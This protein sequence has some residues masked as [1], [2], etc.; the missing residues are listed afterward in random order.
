MSRWSEESRRPPWRRRPS[1]GQ[2]I[3]SL[4]RPPAPGSAGATGSSTAGTIGRRVQLTGSP[5]DLGARPIGPDR[6]RRY[7]IARRRGGKSTRLLGLLRSRALGSGCGTDS[8]SE[9]AVDE[10]FRTELLP[11]RGRA[12]DAASR[13]RAGPPRIGDRRDRRDRRGRLRRSC[14]G[15]QG[16]MGWIIGLVVA[17]RGRRKHL[18]DALVA[19]TNSQ[20][21]LCSLRSPA[22]C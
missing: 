6:A 8:T 9:A 17:R 1:T 19:A 11:G 22:L 5:G 16:I 14:A 7:R 15:Q 4:E 13:T 21:N 3:R 20:L 10:S 2:W 12:V 18:R